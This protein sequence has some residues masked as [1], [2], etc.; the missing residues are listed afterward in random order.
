MPKFLNNKN[1]LFGILAG[2]LVFHYL[3]NGR[4]ANGKRNIDQ[5]YNKEQVL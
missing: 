5:T 1:M 4:K 3:S 2:V